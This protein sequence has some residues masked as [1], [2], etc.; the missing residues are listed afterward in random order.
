[1][2]KLERRKVSHFDFSRRDCSSQPS[3]PKKP[4]FGPFERAERP[5]LQLGTLQP[6]FRPDRVAASMLSI[7]RK[8]LENG[9]LR[10]FSASGPVQPISTIRCLNGPTI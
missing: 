3:N 1:M 9:R 5:F 8:T 2:T 6:H 7:G 4:I 10:H